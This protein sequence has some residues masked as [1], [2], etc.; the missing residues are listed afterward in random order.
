MGQT[1]TKRRTPRSDDYYDGFEDDPIGLTNAFETIK[2]PQSVEYDEGDQAIGLTEA[3]AHVRDA[4]E[5]TWTETGKWDGFDWSSDW[6][7]SAYSDGKNDGETPVDDEGAESAPETADETSH[8]EED[9]ATPAEEDAAQVSPSKEAASE[10]DASVQTP[11]QERVIAASTSPED[12]A[13]TSPVF[14]ETHEI[15]VAKDLAHA[16]AAASHS[17][18]SKRGRHAAYSK[19]LSP[20]MKKSRRTR[21]A[22]IAL[23]V[24]L[25]ALAGVLGAFAFNTVK[26]G[27][28]EAKHQAQEQLETTKDTD[29][30]TEADD[31]I[32]TATQLADVPNLTSLLGKTSKQAIKKLGRGAIVSSN[33]TVKDKKSAIKTNLTVALADEPADSK[34]GTPSVYLGL[35]KRNVI[36]QAGY[37]ASASALGFGSLSFADAISNEHVIEKTLAKIGVDVKEGSA[38]LPKNRAKYATYAKDKSTVV[39]ERCSFEG[40]ID[41]NGVPCTWSA[42]LSYD[43]TTQV[44]TGDLADTVR[45]IYVYISQK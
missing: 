42:V 28:S 25:V 30:D 5:R 45:I 3:F 20:R 32:E 8:A 24:L 2:D 40:D 6:D 16:S 13:P 19:E 38:K 1:M 33:Q 22:L 14:V 44:I 11:D 4:G 29:T 17:A 12:T 31:A 37:S 23:I 43:Y 18:G 27:Q 21:R 7:D 26:E 10:Q 9:A 36:I 35:N 39:K 15:N 41:I 34:T